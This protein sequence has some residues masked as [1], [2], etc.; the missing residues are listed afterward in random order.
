MPEHLLSSQAGS[1]DEAVH[2][3]LADGSVGARTSPF[4]KVAA[5]P[6]GGRTVAVVAG[7]LDIDT[8]QALQHAL[9][10]ALA[11]SVHGLDLDLAGVDFCDCSGLNVLLR[12]RRLALAKAKTVR[13]QTA[14]IAVEHLLAL[15][16]TPEFRRTLRGLGRESVG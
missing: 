15:T 1:G 8:E 3:T 16:R 7:E 5:Y 6:T 9:H 11:Q 12:I 13:I 10:E 4:L 2:E 14:G